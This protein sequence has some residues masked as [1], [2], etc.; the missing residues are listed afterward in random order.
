MGYL[1][2][3][4]SK[5]VPNLY[6]IGITKDWDNRSKQL[7]LK[8]KTT[9]KYLANFDSEIERQIEKDLHICYSQFRLP[10]SEWFLLDY[11]QL[12]ELKNKIYR[13]T[14]Y[15]NGSIV[16]DDDKETLLATIDDAEE[17]L[18]DLYCWMENDVLDIFYEEQSCNN[19][20]LHA[21]ELEIDPV[22][23]TLHIFI[24]FVEPSNRICTLHLYSNY[25][26]KTKST[27]IYF[28][29]S[30][31]EDGDDYDNN[32]YSDN[33]TD[34]DIE[35]DEHLYIIWERLEILANVPKEKYP[36]K[37]SARIIQEKQRIQ[38]Y[39]DL[40]NARSL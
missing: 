35:I 34:N 32:W 30:F 22:T 33:Y 13:S 29:A 16:F 11:L 20:F 31:T 8:Q 36:S 38:K 25:D 2:V 28:A 23:T 18:E 24:S 7:R 1:Y 14:N 6:K 9:A 39:L 21:F 40:E 27:K 3:I 5:S 12:D 15:H 26:A 17:S 19:P 37:I 10:Q 4:K